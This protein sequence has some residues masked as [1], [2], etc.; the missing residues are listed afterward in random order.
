MAC[1]TRPKEIRDLERSF[2]ADDGLSP[3]V[4]I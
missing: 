4:L 3:A 2:A 1:S